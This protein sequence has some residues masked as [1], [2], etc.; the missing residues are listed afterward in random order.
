MCLCVVVMVGAGEGEGEGEVVGIRI[1][2][3]KQQT[4]FYH[5][6]SS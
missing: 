5:Q 4:Y 1:I 2:L 3:T 6:T